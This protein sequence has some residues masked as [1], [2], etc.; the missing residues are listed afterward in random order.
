M[1]YLSQFNHQISGSGSAA[2]KLVFLHGLLGYGANWRRIVRAFDQ[3]Y[4]VL[5]YDQRG[6]GKSI[7]PESGYAPEDF[8]EDLRQILDELGWD[9]IDLVGH[10]MGGRNAVHFAFKYPERVKRLVIEDMG[11]EG[12]ELAVTRME[13][14][15]Y[16]VPTPFE[17]RVAAK[18]FFMNEFVQKFSQ[19]PQV[20][21]LGQFL[22]SNL[23][24]LEDKRMDWRFDREIM[25]NCVREGRA[26]D[27]WEEFLGLQMPTLLIRGETSDELTPEVYQKVVA[28]NNRIQGVEIAEAGHWVH[29]DQPE[30]FSEVIHE[31][32]AK[33]PL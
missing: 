8:A 20:K 17:S 28:E 19:R 27:R 6:H 2:A 23:N 26:R 31:F 29:Y 11:P 14:L 16:G 5:V 7:R 13:E 22:Y 12:S 18:E 9:K 25:L 1:S 33:Q 15:L 3:E 24:E 21:L 4:E 10:S 30:K 32:F